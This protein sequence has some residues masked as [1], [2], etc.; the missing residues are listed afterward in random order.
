MV[1]A[2]AG[3][4]AQASAEWQQVAGMWQWAHLV[5]WAEILQAAG[6]VHWWAGVHSEEVVEKQ[7]L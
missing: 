7:P 2:R 6:R 5:Q 3:H 1:R 4:D